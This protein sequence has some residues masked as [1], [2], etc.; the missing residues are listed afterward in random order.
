MS[1]RTALAAV[2]V[3]ALVIVAAA[4]GSKSS[5][6]S[7]QD[8]ANGLCSAVTDYRTA[9]TSAGTSLKAG[10]LS[11]PELQSTAGDVSDATT[12]FVSDLKGLGKPDT[13]A[14]TQAKQSVDALAGKLQDDADAIDAATKS[15]S[16]VAD[17]VSA[18]ST[19][20]ATLATAGTQVSATWNQLQQLDAKGELTAAFQSADACKSLKGA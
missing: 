2:V 5:S 14:G 7:T 15:V 6:S 9:L 3:S 8:W 18:V 11:R 4:C 19:V 1:V 10:N 17:V 12:T 13:A 16:S 20:T